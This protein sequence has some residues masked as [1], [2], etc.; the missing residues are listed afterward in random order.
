MTYKEQKNKSNKTINDS[1][2]V[3]LYFSMSLY[4]CMFSISMI[5]TSEISLIIIICFIA[6]NVI[7]KQS[8]GS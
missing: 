2:T 4:I 3:W 8:Y 6:V 5:V 7:V 1:M